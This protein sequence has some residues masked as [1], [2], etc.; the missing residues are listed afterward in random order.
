M[1]LDARERAERYRARLRKEG[2]R[3]VQLWLPDT[4]SPKFR[5]QVAHDIAA[6]AVEK[7]HPVD[8]EMLEA[9]ERTAPE[10]NEWR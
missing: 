4:S 2:L 7:L 5:R 1:P 10:D 3:P 9:F 6:L 8:R